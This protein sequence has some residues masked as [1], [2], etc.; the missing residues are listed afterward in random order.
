MTRISHSS[1]ILV[2]RALVFLKSA[3]TMLECMEPSELELVVAE[4][5]S[6][7]RTGDDC[8]YRASNN[9]AAFVFAFME[10]E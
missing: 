8:D 1:D 2:T 10:N 7:L 4:M 3:V 5:Q 9:I 6:Y